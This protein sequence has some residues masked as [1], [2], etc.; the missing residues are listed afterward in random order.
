MIN[1]IKELQTYIKEQ[2]ERLFNKFP[3]QSTKDM[4]NLSSL[5]C[6]RERIDLLKKQIP[7]LPASY[8]K[9]LEKLNLNGVSIG[10]FNLTPSSKHPIDAVENVLEAYEETFFPREFMEKHHMYQIGSN[11]VDM[12]CVTAGTDKFKNGEILF[13]EEGDPYEP[14]DSQIYPL[15]EDFEQFLILAGNANQ[16]AREIKDDDSNRKEKEKEFI[17]RMEILKVPERY[18]KTWLRMI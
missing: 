3:D 11:D 1:N 15:A 9:W 16:L 4:L 13:V 6:L 14:E 2:E 17:K 7:E 18:H 12:V 10:W 8:T 5:G